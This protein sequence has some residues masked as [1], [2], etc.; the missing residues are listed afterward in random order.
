MTYYVACEIEDGFGLCSIKLRSV[1]LEDAII[2]GDDLAN[3]GG[4]YDC[5]KEMPQEA[6]KIHSFESSDNLAIW[7]A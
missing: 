7:Q 4:F 1:N 3:N 6:V 2:E 5:Q